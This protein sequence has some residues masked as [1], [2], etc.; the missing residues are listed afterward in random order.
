[1]NAHQ[2][3]SHTNTLSRFERIIRAISIIL[4]IGFTIEILFL[5]EGYYVDI[6]VKKIGFLWSFFYLL[7]RLFTYII[8]IATFPITGYLFF[9]LFRRRGNRN[10]AF[11]AAIAAA[12]NLLAL[13]SFFA[14]E[15]AMYWRV[16]STYGYTAER[17]KDWVGKSLPDFTFHGIQEGLFPI[18]IKDLQGKPSVFVFWATYDA[19]WSSNFKFAQDLYSQREELGINVFA[20]AVDESK[21]NVTKFLGKYSGGMP[22][23]HDP[24]ASYK[25]RLNIMGSVEQILIIDSVTRLVSVLQSPNS[26]EEIKSVIKRGEDEEK[27][28]GMPPNP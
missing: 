5:V 9:R 4:V 17:E 27:M 16:Q 22:V 19:S 23:Y 15:R 13:L 28:R 26:L 25:H 1:M 8:L 20:I 2:Q 11:T 18:T 3:T 21:D 12:M 6:L 7:F 10:V 24:N 14:F